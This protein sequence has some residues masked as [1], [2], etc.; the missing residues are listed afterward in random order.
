M[1]STESIRYRRS[2]KRKNYSAHT[3]KNYL[4]ILAHFTGWLT[5][6]LQDT[7]RKEI[8]SYVDHLLRKRLSP[9]TITCHL[10]TI[11]LFFDYLIN[12]EEMAMANPVT[13]VSI[14]LPRP[15]PRHLKD[16]QVGKFL[17]VITDPRDRAMFMLMLRCGLR[18][19]EVS[20]LTVDAVELSRSRLFVANGKGGKDRV[21]YLSKDARSS[22][23]AYLKKRSSKI[24]GL[25]LV[26]KGP[27]KGKPISV[28]G[29][30]KRIEYYA[31]LSGV[32]VS[33]HSLRHTMA[34]QLL[35]ADADLSTIQDLLGHTHI[36]TTQRY[37]QVSNL[38]V[39][40]DYY[41]AIELVMQR[42]QEGDGFASKGRQPERSNVMVL[43]TEKE[44]SQA[45]ENP[46]ARPEEKKGPLE[47]A[48]ASSLQVLADSHPV[49]YE[50]V[51]I[52]QPAAS[53][54]SA[55]KPAAGLRSE[56]IRRRLLRQMYGTYR[57]PRAPLRKRPG[58]PLY[59]SGLWQKELR[60]RRD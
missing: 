56:V 45:T 58:L 46:R 24:R 31:H 42:S 2:L 1:E 33:C 23:E 26:Q 39:Q 35:N 15:L 50:P 11:R 36:T 54:P 53:A 30:Q 9:K 14:R 49:K 57:P 18:V 7:T 55:R 43:R 16:D 41:N 34:T 13:K 52:T 29:I 40:R 17:A 25:F 10:Q 32:S 22:L 48:G 60:R 20:R 21:V 12:E 3:I 5:V 28:R 47:T 44:G 19:E 51:E 59:R 27:M 6:P 37:C 8:G 38:K 4:N